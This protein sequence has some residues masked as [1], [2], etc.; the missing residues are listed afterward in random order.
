GEPGLQI[1]WSQAGV[2]RQPREHP[3][4]D[5][6]VVVKCEDDIGPA[7]PAQHAMRS[8]APHDRPADSLEGSQHAPCARA[9]PGRHAAAKEM[10]SS[11]G[12]A[13]PCSSRS[14]MT[15]SARALALAEASSRLTP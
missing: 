11:S 5:L 13:S 4:P 6:L 14:A 2:A 3:G 1:A 7:G 9:G 15:R 10:F 8:R 12:P